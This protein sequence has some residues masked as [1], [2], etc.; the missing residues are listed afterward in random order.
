MLNDF[1]VQIY[2]GCLP[3]PRV[4]VLNLTDSVHLFH[5]RSSTEKIFKSPDASKAVCLRR[6]PR[7][8]APLCGKV[9]LRG[10]RSGGC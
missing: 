9:V 7:T 3:G 10:C 6:H 1:L 5:E 4:R 8:I 2:D